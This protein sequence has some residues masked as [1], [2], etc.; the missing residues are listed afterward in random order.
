M[1]LAEYTPSVDAVN[2]FA[3]E[4]DPVESGGL[5]LSDY[6]APLLDSKYDS[7]TDAVSNL[8]G[9]ATATVVDFGA[10]LWNSLTPEKYNTSTQDL[11]ANI[12]S[13]ALRVYRENEDLVHTASF[14]GGIFAPVGLALKGVGAA[15]AGMKGVNW[16]STAG[17]ESKLAE[18]DD[19]YKA[20]GGATDEFKTLN[21][22]LWGATTA[23]FMVDN[24]AAE[25]AILGTMNAHPFMED[26]V[27]DPAKNFAISL[28]IGA[29]F[30]PLALIADKF[31]VKALTSTT[32]KD[33][34]GA[35]IG[36]T[37][38]TDIAP[39]LNLSGQ[40]AKNMENAANWEAMI[41]TQAE[42]EAALNPYTKEVLKHFSVQAKDKANKLFEQ[43]ASPEIQGMSQEF[44][45]GIMDNMV[46]AP[47]RWQS[48]DRIRFA[49]AGEEAS[50]LDRVGQ[51]LDEPKVL[52]PSGEAN[53][54]D[55]TS[56]DKS[57]KIRPRTM[58]Y[59]PT[60][61]SFMAPRD[62]KQFGHAVDLGT[63]EKNLLDGV[64]SNWFT[65][66]RPETDL[67]F[68]SMS[69]AAIDKEYVKYL[70][71]YDELPF[72]KLNGSVVAP[73]DIPRISAII[74]RSAKF[75]PEE[76]AQFRIT[77]TEN[78]PNY[79]G[80][81]QDALK[82]VSS[83]HLPIAKT[84]LE[85]M[86]KLIETNTHKYDLMD[87]TI[88]S[89]NIKEVFQNNIHARDLY[90]NYDGV[91]FVHAAAEA[92][93][94]A[95]SFANEGVG[96]RL[97]HRAISAARRN[98]A[99]YNK[100]LPV[101]L[102][103][104]Y[105]S[106]GI[107][108]ALASID[109]N[110][111]KKLRMID[112]NTE[113]GI[114]LRAS[115]IASGG[116][117]KVY[118]I[119]RHREKQSDLPLVGMAILNSDQTKL[120][121][122]DIAKLADADGYFY[123]YRGMR[124]KAAG[125]SAGESYT[126]KSS[127]SEG[128]KGESGAV[129]IYKAHIDDII[130]HLGKYGGSTVGGELEIVLDAPTRAY[131]HTL[132]IAKEQVA[133]IKVAN[134]EVTT[135]AEAGIGDLINSMVGGKENLIREMV[136][137]GK[138][139]EAIKIATNLDVN[140]LHNFIFISGMQDLQ[141]SATEVGKGLGLYN[142][143]AAISNYLD[144]KIRALVIET[145]KHK[146]PLAEMRATAQTQNMKNMSD[147]I[148]D[149]VLAKSQSAIVQDFV[150]YIT[151]PIRKGQIAA[152][153]DSLKEIVSESL[154]NRFVGSANFALRDMGDAGKIIPA[155]GKDI[156]EQTNR[157][158][159][160]L[161]KELSPLLGR[162]MKSPAE[163]VEYN[164]AIAVNASLKGYRE[165]KD[166]QFFVQDAN[167]PW[168]QAAD[169]TKT[170][171]M[172]V[173]E[174]KGTEFKV[175]SSTVKQALE[176]QARIGREMFEMMRTKRSA[177]GMAPTN[178]IGF[179]VPAA[180]PRDKYRAYVWDAADSS[181]KL[182][183]AK[184]PQELE[185]LIKAY[186]STIPPGNTNIQVVKAGKE[187]ELYNSLKGRHDEI[188]MES[189]DLASFH[190]GASAPAIISTNTSGMVDMLHS[191]DSYVRNG[192]KDL[193]ELQMSD[194]FDHLKTM[195]S[196]AQEATEKQSVNKIM[197]FL[198]QP[199]DAGAQAR[200]TLL[201]VNSLN[202]YAGWRDFQSSLKTVSEYGLRTIS[203]VLSPLLQVGKGKGT[204]EQYKALMIDL[205]QRGIP[206]PFE[207]FD[208]ATAQRLFGMDKLSG[209]GHLSERAVA[210]S[211][212]LMAT[213]LLKFGELAQPLVNAISLPVLMS[214]A[215]QS[216]QAQT[217]MGSVLD[218]K[219]AS[220]VG[221]ADTMY[222]G[223]RFTFSDEGKRL[224]AIAEKE[225]ITKGMVSEVNGL[226]A[227]SRNLEPGIMTSM[228]K[229]LESK[230]VAVM[231]KPAEMSE[232]MVRHVSLGI[233]MYQA[234]KLYPGLSDAGIMTF[235][236]DFMDNSLGNYVASQ[237]PAMFQ[238]TLGVAMG[239][240]QTYMLTLAQNTYR[241]LEHG[242]F[243]ALAKTM[244]TQSTIF[245]AG[246]LPGFHLVSE[247][248]GEHFS[249][250][251]I[252]LTTGLYKA[253]P[254]QAEMILYGIPSNLG[255]ALYTRGDIQPRVPNIAGGL[256]NLAAVNFVKSVWT[257]GDKLV[258][259]ATMQDVSVGRSLGE[260]LS[261][262]SIS[263]PVAR[264]SELF[265]GNSITSSGNIVQGPEEV[266]S[267]PGIMSRILSTRPMQE[268]KIRDAIHLN[269][270]YG[271]LDSAERQKVTFEL[272]ALLRSGELDPEKLQRL[273]FEYM[274]TGTPTGW[275]SA[276]NEAMRQVEEP[277]TNSIRKYLD[278][279]SPTQLMIDSLDGE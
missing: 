170:R 15:R 46:A 87:A 187:Q 146:I 122:A 10:S 251:N 225:G 27:Q 277:T 148:L 89:K 206:N 244:L 268:A 110:I 28:G 26:Y 158:I 270:V 180:S 20:A 182:L 272:K 117:E 152:L 169:G 195:S 123:V 79:A 9:G 24:I 38:H 41:A 100:E 101:E 37:V 239:L 150:A 132:P 209:S 205:K 126:V 181:T 160:S 266:Y 235:A 257:A 124:N 259:G 18:I 171:N 234:K 229:A 156:T 60:Y 52:K 1:D 69:S 196:M 34:M 245:G 81:E 103:P 224:M 96:M 11:L 161:L 154:G 98:V 47:E 145:D 248:I 143:A 68:N 217:F 109:E 128:F 238:G 2:S 75:T 252:D 240:F 230:L 86:R 159:E 83:G 255:P 231:S 108:E 19:L 121:K 173:V 208:Q 119:E 157:H 241:Q 168:I 8:L 144:P 221:I 57:G 191:Y 193:M 201:G 67:A 213:S 220:R 131:V 178:D 92:T 32:A 211:N 216:R 246:S 22:Q 185:S 184:T 30:T 106:K 66:N 16:F 36:S 256:E 214:A 93:Q 31:A 192:I 141:R 104:K 232:D 118:A 210:L 253:L 236:R 12:D 62:L 111:A 237:R 80:M 35:V 199:K 188:F 54:L 189:A 212:S 125:H 155:L 167:K 219:A 74:A 5:G 55:L 116:A 73:S 63:T 190:S 267:V 59:S 70:K 135:T 200:N 215:I 107:R 23:N 149:G 91:D 260:A 51:L 53:L 94:L 179:W 226:M 78:K 166:G 14:V 112:P 233:G 203:D 97:M 249:D 183:Y 76:A 43:M 127:I 50:I 275:R 172:Q 95:N 44:K 130:G 279:R 197:Q 13:N 39:S 276:V 207:A 61:D 151:T 177:M 247:T 273:S 254:E 274:R 17:R 4:M 85:D 114:K 40:L 265:T 56:V 113:E 194:I 58:V 25:A 174:Y 278:P 115:T 48:V 49:E 147:L 269:T 134:T 153:R 222:N 250:Q 7:H 137:Q 33:A 142:D 165:F 218:A 262:Q 227:Q 71:L 6:Q 29:A 176:E 90:R 202:E 228:E 163:I 105:G 84:H 99:I 264:I 77:L 64:E 175:V 21:R 65:I 129:N 102:L 263:R 139:L 138:G 243:K 72:E 261:L 271:Q 258:E 162:V 133:S 242:Q 204:E 42:G 198:H 140:T 223:L 82:Q 120:L 136:N 45:A 164:T 3:M 186:E 88:S